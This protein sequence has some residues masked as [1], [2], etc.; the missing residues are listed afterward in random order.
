MRDETQPPEAPAAPQRKLKTANENPWYVL[1]TLHGEQEGEEIDWELHER[2]RKAWNSWASNGLQQSQRELLQKRGVEL[3]AR[4]SWNREWGTLRQRFEKEFSNRN[5]GAAVDFS[6]FES[7][8]IDLKECEFLKRFVSSGFLFPFVVE[9]NGSRF[10]RFVNFERAGFSESLTVANSNFAES[11]SFKNS[12]LLE[13]GNFNGCIFKEHVDFDGC[14][15]RGRAD[16][17]WS[18]FDG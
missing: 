8:N 18:R 17:S 5:K 11:A 9:L 10:D 7:R 16:F 15:F 1:M 13:G 14:I 3:P 2:N 4:D 12:V 6:I